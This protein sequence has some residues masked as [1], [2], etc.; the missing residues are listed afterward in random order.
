MRSLVRVLFVAQVLCAVQGAPRSGCAQDRYA[1]DAMFAP[2]AAPSVDQQGAASE[3]NAIAPADTAPSEE[4]T[5]AQLAGAEVIARIDSQVILAC[6]VL[7]RVNMMLEANAD[8]RDQLNPEQWEELRREL[9][10]REVVGLIDRKLL[11]AEFRRN[12]PDGA[13]PQIE[14]NLREPFEEMEMP[15]LEKQLKV[16]GRAAVER[17]LARLGSSLQDARRA[18]NERAIASEMV[19]S[20]VKVKEDVSPEEMLSYYKLHLAD[21]EYPT[22]VRWEELAVDKSRYGSPQEAFAALANMGNEVWRRAST[23]QG[24]RGAVFAE[25]ARAKSDGFT[26]KDG[27]LHDWTSQGA[28]KAT[29]IDEWLFSGQVGQMS[30][31]LDSGPVFHIVRVLER[32]E[33]GRRPFT[34]VQA[35]IREKLKDERFDEGV[36]AHLAKLRKDAKIWTVFTGPTTA[37]AL[38]A[39]R[40]GANRH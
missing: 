10:R 39:N 8:K 33:A 1:N 38:L 5:Q 27:G 34:E 19:R 14:E 18:F 36:Q 31:I 2:P 25:V 9:M 32:Q 26:A 6:D 30:P 15:Q 4:V 11:F 17:E 37:E 20:K 23:H 24:A 35:D 16:K 12:L 28:L 13:W 29:V 22:R 3:L 7:W 40:H 21:Y